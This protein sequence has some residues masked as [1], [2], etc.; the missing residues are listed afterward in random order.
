MHPPLHPLR[1]IRLREESGKAAL[2][3]VRGLSEASACVHTA[4]PLPVCLTAMLKGSS[5]TQELCHLAV[6]K[7]PKDSGEGRV[8]ENKRNRTDGTLQ[9]SLKFC[10]DNGNT[11][12]PF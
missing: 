1:T 6:E 4:P 10:V 2:E 12:I 5:P 8:K 9:V 7:T 3:V 11:K